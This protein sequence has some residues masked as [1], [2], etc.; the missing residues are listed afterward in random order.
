MYGTIKGDDA[1]TLAS[2]LGGRTDIMLFL[3]S[4]TV[5]SIPPSA[6][7]AA[8]TRAKSDSVACLLENGVAG[9]APDKDKIKKK[10]KN[11]KKINK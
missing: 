6:L 8:C 9:M 4:S 1:I 10:K 3:I 11:K 2:R 7:L 5:H